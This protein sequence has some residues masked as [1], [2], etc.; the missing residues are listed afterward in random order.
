MATLRQEL[1]SLLDTETDEII[2]QAVRGFLRGL[3]IGT[4]DRKIPAREN[5]PRVDKITPGRL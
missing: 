1:S 3:L 5:A 2:S 4:A